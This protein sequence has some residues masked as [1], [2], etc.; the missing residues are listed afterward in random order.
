[1]NLYAKV[2]VMRFKLSAVVANTGEQ[3]H[4]LAGNMATAVVNPAM[5][6]AS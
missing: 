3:V 2:Y 1:M 5:V 4:K 6:P